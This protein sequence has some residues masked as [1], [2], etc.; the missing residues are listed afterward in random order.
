[1]G[2]ALF[3]H[4][5]AWSVKDDLPNMPPT[6]AQRRQCETRLQIAAFRVIWRISEGEQTET[7][8]LHPR[9]SVFL[10][11]LIICTLPRQSRSQRIV[12]KPL[13]SNNA[14]HPPPHFI[15]KHAHDRRRCSCFGH[16]A[17][18][19]PWACCPPGACPPRWPL[20]SFPEQ[21]LPS[22]R[23]LLYMHC[24]IP[25]AMDKLLSKPEWSCFDLPEDGAEDGTTQGCF[26]K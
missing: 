1:M 7:L 4:D 2:T 12:R 25:Q 9:L 16:P 17:A 5:C 19:T 14:S 20:S 23:T 6:V 24:Q 26:I 8:S 10:L 13:P 11:S 21:H 15:V 3:V 22:P 18:G